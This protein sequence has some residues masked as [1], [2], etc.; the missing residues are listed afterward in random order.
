MTKDYELT[1][2]VDSQLAEGNA[3]EVVKRYESLLGERGAAVVQ[4]NR[5]GIRKL[6]YEIRKRQQGDYAL[7]QFQA[8]PGVIGEIERA[9]RL[10]ESVLRHLIIHAEGGF[11]KA[12]A[13]DDGAGLPEGDGD[14][15]DE[16]SEEENEA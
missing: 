3:D 15:E 9:C 8:E 4:V 10:D 5:W 13:A 14:L 16:A 1:L 2:I 7:F 12:V 6:A 11:L